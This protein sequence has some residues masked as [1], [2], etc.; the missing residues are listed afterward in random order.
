MNRL[1]GYR[2]GQRGPSVW[3]PVSKL[4]GLMPDTVPAAYNFRDFVSL[5]ADQRGGSCVGQ[6]FSDAIRTRSNIEGHSIDPSALSIY[7]LARQLE[8]PGKKTYA[9]NGS[10][11]YWAVVGL[12]SF[13]IV[14]NSRWP[15]E[16]SSLVAPVYADVLEAADHAIVTG[17]FSIEDTGTDREI[18]IKQAVSEDHPVAFPMPVDQSYMNY[19]GLSTWPGVTGEVIGGHMQYIAGYRDDSVLVKNSWGKNWGDGGFSWVS[20]DW[21]LSENVP[22]LFIITSSPAAVL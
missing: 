22:E 3:K 11:P 8:T 19:S 4:F 21:I 14:A 17:V 15:D 16:T 2:R 13:G 7:T 10:D 9:D 20:W 5:F 1:L 12:K 18:R 6:A